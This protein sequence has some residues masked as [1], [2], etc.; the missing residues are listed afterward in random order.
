MKNELK[1]IP[2]VKPAVK[3]Y[4]ILLFTEQYY[5][6]I[7]KHTNINSLTKISFYS[8]SQNQNIFFKFFVNSYILACDKTP[9]YEARVE[10]SD[11]SLI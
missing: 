8:F 3:I 6:I 5:M 1:K 10:K 11:T 7:L 4:K 9:Q 2:K